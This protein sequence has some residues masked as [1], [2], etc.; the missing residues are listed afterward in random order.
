M[1]MPKAPLSVNASAIKY[2][3]Y[4]G[5][6]IP[7]SFSTRRLLDRG[8]GSITSPFSAELRALDPSSR[9]KKYTPGNPTSRAPTMFPIKEAIKDL[10]G[11]NTKDVDN[12][13]F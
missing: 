13:K 9:R 7:F 4:P 10:G 5:S 8:L 3:A 6:Y 12:T 1:P 2:P 11:E